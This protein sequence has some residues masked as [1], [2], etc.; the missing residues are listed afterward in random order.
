M[1]VLNH[2]TAL[3]LEVAVTELD[4]RTTLPSNASSIVQEARGYL[5]YMSVVDA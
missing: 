3:G 5:H 4:I 2:F 1:S